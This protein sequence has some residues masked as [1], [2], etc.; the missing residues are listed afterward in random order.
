MGTSSSTGNSAVAA[1]VRKVLADTY[2]LYFK[3]HSYHWNVR[4]PQFTSLH[5]L[6]MQQ[7]TELWTSIDA[8]AERIRAVGELAP[9][10]SS[11]LAKES[12]VTEETG[13]PPAE[14][15]I[16]NLIEAHRVT[17]RSV[18]AALEAGEK[19]ADAV[20]VDLMT[21]RLEVHEQTAWM[22]GALLE[23]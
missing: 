17:A 2:M 4:G 6:F 15:M 1:A 10:A 14:Q 16:K 12:S 9:S 11:E 22:L 7:Y 23:R 8:L 19:A 5:E 13:A 21:R 20:T 3:T 18:Q